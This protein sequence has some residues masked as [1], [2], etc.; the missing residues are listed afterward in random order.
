MNT[1][2]QT[3]V[4]VSKHNRDIKCALERYEMTFGLCLGKMQRFIVQFC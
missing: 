4:Y 2:T 3:F 1:N